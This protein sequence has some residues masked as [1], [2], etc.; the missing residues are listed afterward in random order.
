MPLYYEILLGFVLMTA[1]ISW[2]ISHSLSM[3]NYISKVLLT[4]WGE[5]GSAE[6]G[7]G[8]DFT[9]PEHSSRPKTEHR[10]WKVVLAAC[11]NE[12]VSAFVLP[13]E[14]I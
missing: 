7:G 6:P 8:G 3:V 11:W 2:V 12:M 13:H 1:E 9:S 14:W 10:S 4:S 5:V